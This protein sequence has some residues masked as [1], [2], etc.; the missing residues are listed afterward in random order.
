MRIVIAISKCAVDLYR[1]CLPGYGPR[2][3]L[4]ITTTVLLVFRKDKPTS[5]GSANSCETSSLSAWCV[6]NLMGDMATDDKKDLQE[7]TVWF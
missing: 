7:L 2:P 3:T 1:Y 5:S 6:R 4:D